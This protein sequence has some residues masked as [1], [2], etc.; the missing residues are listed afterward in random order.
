MDK[1]AFSGNV[2]YMDF[3]YN[4]LCDTVRALE[5]LISSFKKKNEEIDYYDGLFLL[6]DSE[7]TYGLAFIAMQNYIYGSIYDH[8]K[9]LKSDAKIS[10]D[11]F[12]KSFKV[13]GE[14]KQ[15]IWQN[16]I[17]KSEKVEQNDLK[18]V[19]LII[20]LANYYKH[21]DE[22]NGLDKSTLIILNKLD[23]KFNENN[24]ELDDSPI[25]NG[26]ELLSKNWDLTEIV[27]NI[28]SWREKLWDSN[29][30]PTP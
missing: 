3:R 18:Y 27:E 5:N 11:L 23:N 21:R 19:E 15:H 24:F 14:L 13:R 10:E 12:E 2:M 17:P 22:V 20:C 30:H 28:K 4:Y 29:G 8:L 7:Q 1:I 9:A 6:E 26:I 25:I 16:Y